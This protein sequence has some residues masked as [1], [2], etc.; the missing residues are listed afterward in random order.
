ME[1]D[2]RVLVI[3]MGGPRQEAIRRMLREIGGFE[4]PVFSPGVRSRD[5]NNRSKFLTLCNQAGLL[6]AEEWDRL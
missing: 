3:S 6:P 1:R 2:I 5:L 4:E